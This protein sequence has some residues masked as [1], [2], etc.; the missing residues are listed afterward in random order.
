VVLQVFA[1][2]AENHADSEFAGA[3]RIIFFQ[4]MAQDKVY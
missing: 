1:D 4:K 2:V 3:T